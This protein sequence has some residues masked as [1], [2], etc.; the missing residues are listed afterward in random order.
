MLW[1]YGA[2]WSVYHERPRQYGA[3]NLTKDARSVSLYAYN[4]AH[5]LQYVKDTK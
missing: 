5:I 3:S 2:I 4:R 1:R